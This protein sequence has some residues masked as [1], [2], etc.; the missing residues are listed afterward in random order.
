M[1]TSVD[2]KGN[3]IVF[4][5]SVS[6]SFLFLMIYIVSSMS[7]PALMLTLADEYEPISFRKNPTK[8]FSSIP[9][10]LRIMAWANVSLSLGAGA[11]GFV[12]LFAYPIYFGIESPIDI[13]LTPIGLVFVLE[14]DNWTFLLV[15]N[16]QK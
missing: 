13:I 1:D 14:M 2:S 12:V 5:F 3:V 4:G 6:M 8:A 11:L 16:C 10:L 7:N 9:G 15:W